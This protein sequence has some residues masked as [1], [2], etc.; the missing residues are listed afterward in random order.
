[1]LNNTRFDLSHS[2]FFFKFSTSTQ[3]HPTLGEKFCKDLAIDFTT[4]YG[5]NFDFV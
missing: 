1:M 5:G 3:T 2:A 4:D